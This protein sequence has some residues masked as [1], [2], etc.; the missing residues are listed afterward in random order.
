MGIPLAAF[1]RDPDAEEPQR[2][3]GFPVDWFEPTR[4]Q[5]VG[6]MERYVRRYRRWT[7]RRPP[8]A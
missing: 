2:V 5:L 8:R 1:S 7:R 3:L 6:F 4:R